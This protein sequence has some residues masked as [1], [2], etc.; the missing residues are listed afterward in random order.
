MMRM[1]LGR[2]AASAFRRPLSPHTAKA[3]ATTVISRRSSATTATAAPDKH[4][5]FLNGTNSRYIG[6]YS[7]SEQC[8]KLSI[9]H[10]ERERGRESAFE[11]GKGR[12]MKERERERER[13]GMEWRACS[14]S[15]SFFS[16]SLCPLRSSLNTLIYSLSLSLRVCDHTGEE[17]RREDG[18]FWGFL[19]VSSVFFLSS[20]FFFFFLVWCGME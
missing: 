3:T 14:L 5:Q 2:V 11:Y 9:T 13:E 10:T 18:D 17:K 6:A 12:A 7:L 19:S 20:F 15:L 1:A 4:E 8:H 16:I